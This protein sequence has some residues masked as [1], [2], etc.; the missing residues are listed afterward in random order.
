MFRVF[1]CYF[2]SHISIVAQNGFIV[3]LV[4]ERDA[5]SI[6]RDAYIIPLYNPD[7]IQA[8]KLI[9]LLDNT[10]TGGLIHLYKVISERFQSHFSEYAL[11]I[12]K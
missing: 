10:N 8:I 11:M 2:L 3:V 12:L 1:A 5:T 6:N 9:D 4:Q 7:D